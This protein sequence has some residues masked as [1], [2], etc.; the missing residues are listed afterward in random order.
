M[1]VVIVMMFCMVFIA[2]GAYLFLNRPQEGDECEGKDENGNYVIDDEGECVLDN[3]VS[4]YYKSGKECL[5][6]QSG[7]DCEPEGTPDPGGVYLTDQVG[8][9]ELSSCESPYVIS[10]DKCVV[11]YEF[12]VKEETERQRTHDDFNIHITDIRADGVRVTS[13]QLVMHEEPEW[14]KCNSKDGGYECEGENYGINDPEPVTPAMN[15]LTWS[16]W[17]EGQAV[18][19]TKLLTIT[20]PSKVAKFEMDFFRP[21]YVPGWTI[22][23]NGIEVLSTSKGAN[24]NTPTPSTVEYIIP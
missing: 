24:Q 7:E 8:G 6:D 1:I 12:I 3:C 19:G 4:G 23:E 15:D 11:V 2:V 14:A 5:V 22:K 21:K 10:G 13:D 9:C 18:T 20:M 16:A 17:K